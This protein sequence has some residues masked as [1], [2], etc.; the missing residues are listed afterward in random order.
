MLMAALM[1]LQMLAAGMLQ[2]LWPAVHALGSAKIPFLLAVVL[3][4]ATRHGPW[5]VLCAALLAGIM[6]DSLSQIPMGYSALCFVMLGLL[7]WRIRDFIFRESLLAAVVLGGAS[8]AAAS[9]ALLQMLILDGG[10]APP[11]WPTVVLKIA[12]SG[13]LGIAVTPLVWSAARRMDRLVGLAPG[14]DNDDGDSREN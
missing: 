7:V 9:A 11:P 12:G 13:V 6:Q 4:Y 3:Y 14:N 5:S 10:Y 1:T 8:G 2:S